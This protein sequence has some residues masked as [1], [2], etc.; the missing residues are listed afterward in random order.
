[1][2]ASLEKEILIEHWLN[3]INLVFYFPKFE[4]DSIKAFLIN[5]LRESL[6]TSESVNLFQK[7]SD[8]FLFSG[9]F[10]EGA[11]F[12][13]NINKNLPRNFFEAEFDIMFP[14]AKVLKRK[15]KDVI[16]DL[17]YAKGFTW[18]RFDSDL[19]E[20]KSPEQPEKFLVEHL[21]GNIYI[22]S[23]TVKASLHSTSI[24]SLEFLISIKEIIQEPSNNWEVV[25]DAAKVNGHIKDTDKNIMTECSKILHKYLGFIKHASDN[26]EQ[27]HGDILSELT[28]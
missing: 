3:Q 14:T 26:L 17:E 11:A 15:S 18:V 7:F 5:M 28:N 9:S 19:V 24:S 21:D 27:F 22:N 8:S 4:N 1:M 23:N 6:V 13:R 2:D 10:M 20:W 25:S 16:L 12:I